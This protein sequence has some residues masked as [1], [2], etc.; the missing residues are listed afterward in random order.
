MT[1]YLEAEKSIFRAGSLP[2]C[3]TGSTGVADEVEYVASACYILLHSLLLG[4]IGY[5]S[6]LSSEYAHLSD[7][8]AASTSPYQGCL[9]VLGSISVAT[10]HYVSEILYV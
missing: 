2:R 10:R 3:S 5:L 8:K 6:N 4:L 9:T 1:E 7:Y